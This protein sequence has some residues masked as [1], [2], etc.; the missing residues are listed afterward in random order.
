MSLSGNKDVDMEIILKL[1]D[2]ELPRVCSV[3]KYVNKICESDAF[4]YRRL[5]NKINL[6]KKD[7]F[8]KYKDLENIEV[9]GERIREMQKYFGLESLKELNIFLNK[10]PKNALYI[11]YHGF[12]R[13]NRNIESAFDI[14]NL[15]KYINR[16]ELIY[17]LRRNVSINKY[18]QMPDGITI[19]YESISF[20]INPMKKKLIKRIYDTYKTLG[21]I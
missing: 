11:E 20:F 3:N 10:L 12:E 5:I 6:V 21:I 14:S 8:S 16:E 1:D 18:K 17:E 15:P 13:N 7:N 2:S 4:W 9:T 19:P